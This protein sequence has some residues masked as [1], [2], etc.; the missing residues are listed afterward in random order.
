MKLPTEQKNRRAII[1]FN[2]ENY[3]PSAMTITA[4][5]ARSLQLDLVGIFVMD[6]MLEAAMSY[7][8]AREF[9]TT[10]RNWRILDPMELRHEQ[11]IIAKKIS[12][13]LQI[14][15]QEHQLSTS[16]EIASG[17]YEDVVKGYSNNTDILI[18]FEPNDPLGQLTKSFDS[19]LSTAMRMCS[20]AL[21]IPKYSTHRKG[22]IVFF[23]SSDEDPR[24]EIAS[25]IAVSSEEK[26][27]LV[28][29]HQNHSQSEEAFF[30]QIQK[31]ELN[32]NF[33]KVSLIISSWD[34]LKGEKNKVISKICRS[35]NLPL[36]MLEPK[37]R[38]SHE[39]EQVQ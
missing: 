21:I 20:S 6:Q 9:S 27:V 23:S 18:F 22:E 32:T 39:G 25:R 10:F 11:G 3:N 14:K 17:K 13:D 33:K 35:R 16:F 38:E 8:G 37:A 7:S 31:S 2:H 4:A 30:S 5:L 15:A 34:V 12:K 28:K 26:L 29:T 36:L 19:L 24:L 1:G